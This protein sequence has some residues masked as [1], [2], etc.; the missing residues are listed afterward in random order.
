MATFRTTNIMNIDHDYNVKHTY[1]KRDPYKY[2][3]SEK[4]FQ[5]CYNR[6][7]R[8]FFTGSLLFGY[9]YYSIRH[10]Q[11]LGLVKGLKL[12]PVFYMTTLP[13]AL[14]IAAVSYPLGYTL[15]VDFD[16]KKTHQIAKIELM[17]FDETW[18]THDDFKYALLNTPIYSHEDSK[19]GRRTSVRGLF[20]Y[21]QLPGYIRRRRESNKDI[22]N[23]VPP[24][25]EHT[26]ES[27]LKEVLPENIN[28]IPKILQ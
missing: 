5:Q 3:L 2:V 4:E 28:K 23:D 20:N 10:H 6:P 22:V 8:A 15:F 26:P 13:K 19:F 9:L 7:K 24:K 14:L 21:Y 17:K 16:K 12:S 27:P 1:I 18:F 11:E 25:Y